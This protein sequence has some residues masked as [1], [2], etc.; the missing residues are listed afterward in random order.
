MFAVNTIRQE[1]HYRRAAFDTGLQKLGYTMVP[2]GAR[3]KGR[4]DL[5]LVWNLN[6]PN[7][8]HA[9][10]WEGAGGSVLVCENGYLGKDANGHQLY[11]ISVHGHNGSGWFPVGSEDRFARLGIELKPWRA[12]AGYILV[13][14]QRGIGSRQMASPPG[15][16]DRVAKSLKGMGQSD[17][18]LRRHPGRYTPE[19]TLEQDL[20]GA[21]LCLI[22]SSSSG[23]TALTQGVPV[24]YCAPH[25]ICAGAATRGLETLST[26]C[27]SDESRSTAMRRMAYG[28]WTVAEIEAGEPFKAI[29]AELEHATWQ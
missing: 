5:L 11:A 14:G 2:V 21:R 15:W 4:H 16:E 24:V 10:D 26:L 3:P 12:D 29:L 17:L 27:A 6:P 13:C 9:I 1:P 19:T 20:A 8:G 22:W 28:Q 25:W 7:E 23:V 18:K